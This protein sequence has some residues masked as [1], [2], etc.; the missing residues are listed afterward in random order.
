MLGGSGPDLHR[1][2]GYAVDTDGKW[3]SPFRIENSTVGERQSGRWRECRGVG[4]RPRND[5]DGEWK[6]RGSR[7]CSLVPLVLL[8]MSTTHLLARA[9]IRDGD[10]VLVVQADGQSHTFL[11]GGH[12]EVGEGLEECLRREL[13][14]ELCVK[15][16]VETYLGGVEHQWRRDGE[17]QYEINHCFSVTVPSLTADTRPTAEEEHLSFAWVPV[18]RLDEAA[19]EPAPLRPLLADRRATKT[20]W[21]TSTL[22]RGTADPA[23]A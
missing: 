20:P 19:L 10:H 15:A 11:P 13:R 14:E 17:R 22:P 4:T 21:W 9:V 18:D 3:R 6:Q 2:R 12:R 8:P 7:T 5:L 23:G 1:F 16:R